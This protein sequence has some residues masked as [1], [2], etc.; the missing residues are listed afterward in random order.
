M[1]LPLDMCFLQHGYPHWMALSKHMGEGRCC[2]TQHDAGCCTQCTARKVVILKWLS[3]AMLHASV[4]FDVFHMPPPFCLCALH[5]LM[6]ELPWS[7]WIT[8]I[9]AMKEIK[10][11]WEEYCWG[12]PGD[13]CGVVLVWFGFL[14]LGLFLP[15][16]NHIQKCRTLDT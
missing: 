12:A 10:E 15:I 11:R 13:F 9:S 14:R 16:L 6:T 7:F 8:P 4:L 5:G 2:R 1:P 3:K